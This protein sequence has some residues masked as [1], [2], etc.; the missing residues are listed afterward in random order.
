[1]SNDGR[2]LRGDGY[3][4]IVPAI[5]RGRIRLEEEVKLLQDAVTIYAS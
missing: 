5:A 2:F 3:L 4:P 1:M